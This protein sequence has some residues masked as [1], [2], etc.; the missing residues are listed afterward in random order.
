M[1]KPNPKLKA[2]CLANAAQCRV[3]IEEAEREIS[4]YT[5]LDEKRGGDPIYTG[6]IHMW[7]NRLRTWTECEQEQIAKAEVS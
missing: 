4:Y 5:R 3:W 7:Q 6:D 1:R 2:S